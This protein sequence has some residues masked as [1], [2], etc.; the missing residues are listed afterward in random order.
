M[1]VQ[2]TLNTHQIQKY[3]RLKYNGYRYYLVSSA[4]TS[5]IWFIR[6]VI[7]SRS[8]S[9]LNIHQKRGQVN[10]YPKFN[11][12]NYIGRSCTLYITHT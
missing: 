6:N 2:Y 8:T 10:L 9:R 5:N 1:H 11:L 3:V 4:Y 12:Y 7:Q